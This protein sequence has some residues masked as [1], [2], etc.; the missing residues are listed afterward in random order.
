MVLLCPRRSVWISRWKFQIKQENGKLTAKVNIQGSTLE[1]NDIKAKGD[2]YTSSFYVD[3]TP[4]D[5][6]MTQKGNKLE[7]MADA[8]GMQIPVKFKKTKK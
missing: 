8:G 1:I 3:G 2:T 5:L 7:G 4:V 6:T